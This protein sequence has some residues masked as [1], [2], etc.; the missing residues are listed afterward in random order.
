MATTS[1]LAVG[2][3]ALPVVDGG[4]I[5]VAQA[6]SC[7]GGYKRAQINGQTKCLRRGQFCARAA[8]SQY[9][10][11]GYRCTRYDAKVR[12]YRLT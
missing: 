12:R 4:P 1:L 3:A 9:R 6:K 2:S 8:D 7:S 10:R 5:A 11:Y